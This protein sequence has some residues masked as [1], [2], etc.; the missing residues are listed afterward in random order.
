MVAIAKE[1]GTWNALD[2]VDALIV[3]RDLE[4]ALGKNKTA[5]KHWEKFF[6]FFKTGNTRMDI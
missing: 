3:P 5:L 2:N 4:D 6:S 1:K